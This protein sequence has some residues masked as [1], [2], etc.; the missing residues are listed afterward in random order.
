[1]SKPAPAVWINNGTKACVCSF[2][3]DTVLYCIVLCGVVVYF[4]LVPCVSF[5]SILL[6]ATELPALPAPHGL[7][8]APPATAPDC[9][10]APLNVG[11]YQRASDSRRALRS[12]RAPMRHDNR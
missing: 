2:L 6:I 3:Y 4:I 12:L 1:M 8:S 9:Q 11:R 10:Q 5:C 7:P